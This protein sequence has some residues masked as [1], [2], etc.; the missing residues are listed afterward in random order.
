M[1]IGKSFISYIEKKWLPMVIFPYIL[2]EKVNK[3]H[4]GEPNVPSKKFLVFARILCA[5]ISLL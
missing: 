1:Y 2:V 4:S 3:K 5:I